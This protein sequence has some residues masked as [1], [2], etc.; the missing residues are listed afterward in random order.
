[1]IGFKESV[2]GQVNLP[3]AAWDVV[4]FLNNAGDYAKQ[5]GQ[6]L[7]ILM[8]IAVLIWG[9]VK[10]AM[11]VMASP[12]SAGQQSSWGMIG[13]MI[14]VGGAMMIGGFRLAETVGSGGQ[15]TITDMGGGVILLAQLMGF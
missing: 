3:S 12:Q 9:F 10:L 4:S 14:L 6:P 5:V 8:G 11:K 13:V 7:L 2:I 15:D 1:M